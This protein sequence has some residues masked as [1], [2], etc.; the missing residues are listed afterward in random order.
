M[1]LFLTSAYPLGGHAQNLFQLVLEVG[2][3]R[4]PR[5][6][7]PFFTG[8]GLNIQILSASGTE[9]TAALPANDLGRQ[10][11]KNL[12]AQNILLVD[13]LARVITDLGLGLGDGA[14]VSPRVDSERAV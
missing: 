8:A 4:P 1:D 5:I 3:R 13:A 10:S 12:F 9:S 14:F 11:Q 7:R 2:Q 6:R